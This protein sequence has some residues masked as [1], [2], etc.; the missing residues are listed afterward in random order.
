MQK[1]QNPSERYVHDTEIVCPACGYTFQESYDFRSDS[2]QIECN[3]CGAELE[4]CRDIQVYYTTYLKEE[5]K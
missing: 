1:N 4:Y 5:T 3:D 2:G